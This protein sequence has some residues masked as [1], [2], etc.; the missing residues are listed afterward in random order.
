MLDLANGKERIVVTFDKDFGELIFR[1]KL[2]ARGLIIQ[3]EGQRNAESVG[4]WWRRLYR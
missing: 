1:E 4:H 2:K 3:N